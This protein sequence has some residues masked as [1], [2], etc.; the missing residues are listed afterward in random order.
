MNKQ[1]RL[2]LVRRLIDVGLPKVFRYPGMK[3]EL[4]VYVSMGDVEAI[5]EKR[6]RALMINLQAR[7]L[8][9]LD[10]R[11]LREIMLEYLV[12]APGGDDPT[13]SM[14]DAPKKSRR[15]RR[16]G[17]IGLTPTITMGLLLYGFIGIMA[18]L[19]LTQQPGYWQTPTGQALSTTF[20]ITTVGFVLLAVIRNQA[21]SALQ[22]IFMIV[23]TIAVGA[24][25]YLG[26]RSGTIDLNT[27]ADEAAANPERA[28]GFG[29]L[30]VA[31]AMGF[32]LFVLRR[33]IGTALL[34]IL[35]ILMALL[36]LGSLRF[37]GLDINAL[38]G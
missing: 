12:P 4:Q 5:R 31:I 30:G 6:L 33:I 9:K 14:D 17:G 7:Q 20:L 38:S 21:R 11:R 24:A 23:L 3:E 13:Y 36:A 32:M 34:L 29:L 19:F 22:L 18:I 25:V 35:L 16:K 26:V 2:Q 8:K 1:E 27:L 28:V 37:G 15:K 10:E